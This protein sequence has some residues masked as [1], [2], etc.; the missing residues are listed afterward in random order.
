MVHRC[1]WCDRNTAGTSLRTTVQRGERAEWRKSTT[2]AP[3]ATPAHSCSS[4]SCGMSGQ[5]T[6]RRSRGRVSARRAVE[7]RGSGQR[8]G[9]GCVARAAAA[10]ATGAHE[11]LILREPLA[12]VELARPGHALPRNALRKPAEPTARPRSRPSQ[13]AATR[14]HAPQKHASAAAS[15]ALPAP[16]CLRPC[17]HLRASR[18]RRKRR[19]ENVTARASVPEQP[20]DGRAQLPGAPR[21]CG[22]AS[23]RL[24]TAAGSM[25]RDGRAAVA[26]PVHGRAPRALRDARRCSSSSTRHS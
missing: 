16:G 17:A 2:R 11:V 24:S 9:K 25:A 26:E 23:S 6:W 13:R 21:T 22:S 15:G 1:E 5:L 8:R 14:L 7:P 10:A 20:R 4:E 18:P 3:P 12:A 19:P